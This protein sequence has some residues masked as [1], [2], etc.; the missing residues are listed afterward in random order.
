VPDVASAERV[1]GGNLEGRLMGD[2]AVLQKENAVRPH[3]HRVPGTLVAFQLV[4][5]FTRIRDT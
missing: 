3:R 5:A 1:D 2:L 4:E